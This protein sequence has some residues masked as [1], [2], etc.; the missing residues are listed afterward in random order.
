[1]YVSFD[2]LYQQCFVTFTGLE[3]KAVMIDV[4]AVICKALWK[5]RR[6]SHFKRIR[7][8]DPTDI[9]IFTCH[10]VNTWAKL[11]IGVLRKAT[12]TWSSKLAKVAHETSWR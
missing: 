2:S 9:I 12:T 3:G 10:F 1:M 7:H 6:K 5:T 8:K 4:V 11:H